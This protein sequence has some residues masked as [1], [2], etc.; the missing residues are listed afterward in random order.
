MINRGR[1]AACVGVVCRR[2]PW[3]A[4]AAI[5]VVAVA[6]G[7]RFY[8]LG[9]PLA[10]HD[11][12]LAALNSAGTLAEVVQNTRELNSSPLLYPLLLWAVQQVEV[13]PF[14]IR[15]LPALSGVLTV[16]VIL[17]LPRF[18]VRREAALLAA[19]LAALAPAAIYEA[20][21]AREYGVDALVAALLIAG[22]LWYRRDGRKWLLCGALLAAPLLQYGL[23][24]F[25]A[26]IIGAGLILP[27]TQDCLA[28]TG[29]SRRERIKGWVR[30]RIGLA[31][32]TAFF[33]AGCAVS[34]LTTLRYHLEIAGPGFVMPG[35]YQLKMAGAEVVF[36]PYYQNLYFTGE[37]RVIPALEF[38]FA[39]LWGIAGHHLPLVVIIA[40]ASAVG[41]GLARL[42]GAGLVFRRAHRGA[43]GQRA[44]PARR[45]AGGHWDVVAVVLLLALGT[46]ICAGLSRQYPAAATRHITYLG[47]AVFVFSGVAL[48]GAIQC[49]AVAGRGAPALKLHRGQLGRALTA[50]AAVV[51]A[52]ASVV[53]IQQSTLY[54][55][56]KSA[57]YFA[58]LEE[59]VQADDIVYST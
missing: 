41:I 40:V 37:Y 13:S 59:L 24:L 46:A 52:G 1:L 10:H 45:A 15:L 20:R 58:V 39:S 8:E 4:V 47:P 31:W 38:A 3:Y 16:G 18:G 30:R 57:D 21:G 29:Q 7:L 36:H 26:A 44:Q 55:A 9:E 43:D 17:L 42:A 51:L 11:E 23:V 50:V 27:P 48:A 32:P 34:A 35:L 49:L 28:Q 56:V 12:A 5:C 22:L 53:A 14:S 2:I 25:G 6:A 54:R 19:I 33:L